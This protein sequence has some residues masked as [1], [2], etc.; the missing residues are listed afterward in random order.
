MWAKSLLTFF[1]SMFICSLFVMSVHAKTMEDGTYTIPYEV[2]KSGES[3]ISIANDY[4]KKPAT[5]IVSNGQLYL[6]IEMGKSH[7]TKKVTLDGEKETVVQ[8]DEKKDERTI[9]FPLKQ[10]VG[11]HAGTID[12]YINEK[13]DGEDFLYDNSYEIDFVFDEKKVLKQ[14]STAKAIQIVE[15]KQVKE[16]PM[17]WWVYLVS[18]IVFFLIVITVGKQIKGRKE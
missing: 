18:G 16:Q 13:V 12:V 15:K 9:Q 8:T 2:K 6:E 7:W 3:S 17:G 5:L 1:I 11:K 4:F 14:S 10:I